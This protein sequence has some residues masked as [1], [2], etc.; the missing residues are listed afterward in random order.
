GGTGLLLLRLRRGLHRS[1]REPLEENIREVLTGIL[2]NLPV[3]ERAKAMLLRDHDVVLVD[4]ELRIDVIVEARPELRLEPEL[5]NLNLS[6][7]ILLPLGL[8]L[9]SE[10]EDDVE[11]EV[12]DVVHE[13]L[14]QG[15][16]LLPLR[17]RVDKLPVLRLVR[18]RLLLHLPEDAP[19]PLPEM[20]E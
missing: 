1:R 6:A 7:V 9:R 12:S 20:R 4:R 19:L 8:L 10:A 18:S 13:H 15:V 5:G 3:Q 2:E 17:V 16:E 11:W 14:V